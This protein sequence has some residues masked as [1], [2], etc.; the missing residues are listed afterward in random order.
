MRIS[1]YFAAL[2]AIL[3]PTFGRALQITAEPVGAILT[4]SSIHLKV[5]ISELDQ[6]ADTAEVTFLVDGILLQKLSLVAGETSVTLKP[7]NL[8]LGRHTLRIESGETIETIEL[9]AMLGWLSLLPPVIAIGLALA[10]RMS[11]SRSSSEYSQAP[12]FST[13]G[14]LSWPLLDRSINLSRPR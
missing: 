1:L 11:F 2:L 6:T 8:S 3:S 12:S 4:N 7:A 5:E 9:Q 13:T 10:L 14:T